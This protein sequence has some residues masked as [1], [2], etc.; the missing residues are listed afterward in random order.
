MCVI[1][2]KN[3]V[4]DALVSPS[5][6]TPDAAFDFEEDLPRYRKNEVGAAGTDH[7]RAILLRYVFI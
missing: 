7:L 6:A 1:C 4:A 3:F 5:A 2:N